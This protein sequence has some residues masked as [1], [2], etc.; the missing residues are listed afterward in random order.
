MNDEESV[1]DTWQQVVFDMVVG[2]HF[3]T[4]SRAF[5]LLCL[6]LLAKLLPTASL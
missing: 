5:I 4:F 6:R 3:P 2:V 1:L